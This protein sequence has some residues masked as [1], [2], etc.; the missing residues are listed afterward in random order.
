MVAPLCNHRGYIGN[1]RY[2][3]SADIGDTG[4]SVAVAGEASELLVSRPRHDHCITRNLVKSQTTSD[5]NEDNEE[6]K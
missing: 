5:G 3:G 1:Y 4:D 2:R 6:D